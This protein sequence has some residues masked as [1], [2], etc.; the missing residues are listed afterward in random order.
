MKNKLFSGM[1]LICALTMFSPKAQAFDE[2]YSYQVITS[3]GGV[4]NRTFNG[5]AGE[6]W[7]AVNEWAASLEAEECGGE[8][9]PRIRQ[10]AN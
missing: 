3:C 8:G 10:M 1:A 6:V 7:T 4:Y 5:S 2:S 9:I